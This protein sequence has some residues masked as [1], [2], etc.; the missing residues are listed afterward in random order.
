MAHLSV[1]AVFR[2]LVQTAIENAAEL[3]E[4]IGVDVFVFPQPVELAGAEFVVLNQA[5]L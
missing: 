2:D 3:V 5:I 1:A 4:R